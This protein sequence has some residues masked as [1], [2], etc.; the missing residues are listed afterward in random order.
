MPALFIY[1]VFRL[2]IVGKC[3]RNAAKRGAA[4]LKN[5]SPPVAERGQ[6]EEEKDNLKVEL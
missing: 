4:Q 2:E 5:T 6:P 1:M 3:R